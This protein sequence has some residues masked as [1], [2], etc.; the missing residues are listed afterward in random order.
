MSTR[1]IVH[2][3]LKGL[4]NG[5]LTA[6]NSNARAEKNEEIHN[7]RWTGLVAW[8]KSLFS[9]SGLAEGT[10]PRRLVGVLSKICQNAL[11]RGEL[12]EVIDIH[13]DAEF[14]ADETQ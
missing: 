3:F 7:V 10:K 4:V 12:V 2:R 13:L 9:W 5:H 14:L 8:W 1:T 11:I 6:S